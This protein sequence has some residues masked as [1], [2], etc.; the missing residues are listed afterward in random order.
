LEAPASLVDLEGRVLNGMSFRL[1]GGQCSF[2]QAGKFP[3]KLQTA[4]ATITIPPL[5][6]L[7]DLMR[8]LQP[9]QKAR[10]QTNYD[11]A[12]NPLITWSVVS[13]G[14]SFSQGEFTAPATPGTT[15]VRATASVGNQVADLTINIPAV[16]T[17][18]IAAA[19]PG[20]TI[21]FN[22]NIASPVWTASAGT[23]GAGTGVWTA[24]SL[25]GQT[26]RIQAGN[27]QTASIDVLILDLFPLNDPTLPVV[28]DRNLTALIS[29]SED[30]TS[31][32]TREK[33]P[34]FDSY[35]IKFTQRMIADSNDVDAFFDAHGFGKPFILEDTVRGVRKIGWFDSP[36]RHEGND[37]CSID[38]SFRFLEMRT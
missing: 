7:G 19:A 25:A 1:F 15:I 21:T 35:E 27:A 29:M 20:E 12:Q 24:P 37:E 4:E 14:G 28:W 6:I 36:I 30:R 2:D 5:Q 31:R 26:V 8:T 22:T 9:G 33:A 17:P 3:G 18:A 34:P 10:F 11:A 23:I 32:I 16:I 38:L 13:G